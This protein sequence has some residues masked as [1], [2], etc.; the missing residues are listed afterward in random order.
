M[1]RHPVPAYED[2]RSVMEYMWDA[3]RRNGI[4]IGVAPNIEVSLIVNPDDARYLPKR[5]LQWRLYE[6]K[7]ALMRQ[8]AKPIFKKELRPRVVDG[9]PYQCPTGAHSISE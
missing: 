6:S 2:M 8:A 5:N 7:L 9:D 4:P 3:C 1:E